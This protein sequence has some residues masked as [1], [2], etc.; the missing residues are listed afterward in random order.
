M[1]HHGIEERNDSIEKTKAKRTLGF[2]GKKVIFTFGYI[3]SYKGTELLIESAKFLATPNWTLVITG[4]PHPRLS[5]NSEYQKYVLDLREKASNMFKD[6]IIFKGFIPEGEI[7]LYFSAA[8]L[9]VFPY[10]ICMHTSGPLALA[11]SYEK[12]FLISDSFKG[13]FRGDVLFRNNPRDLAQ[14]MDQF[15]KDAKMRLENLKYVKGLK[16][17]RVWGKVAEQSCNLYLRVMKHV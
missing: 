17:E 1:I 8:D 15:F 5:G 12:P 3:T 14:K 16:K 4:G 2:S 13:V 7:P 6:R 10:K 11:I 9:T